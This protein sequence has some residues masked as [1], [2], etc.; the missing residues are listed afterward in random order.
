MLVLDDEG[1]RAT[2]LADD[3]QER[4]ERLGVYRREA[5]PSKHRSSPSML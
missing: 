1:G 5:R 4:L 3:V 2:L